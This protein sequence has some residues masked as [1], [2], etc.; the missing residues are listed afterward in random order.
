MTDETERPDDR[1][2]PDDR[3]LVRPVPQHTD[4]R[5]A[6]FEPLGAEALGHQRNAHVVLSEPGAVR[7]NHVH[8]RATEVLV[9]HGPALV[10]YREAGEVRDVDVPDAEVVSFTIP[11]GVPHAIVHTG[12]RQGLLVAF[13]DTAHDPDDPDTERVELL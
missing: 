7:G 5:G 8:R 11:P 2:D 13:R 6:V 3:V 10:R 12:S 4:P 1:R 9:V